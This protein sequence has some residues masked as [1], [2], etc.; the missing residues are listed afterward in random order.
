LGSSYHGCDRHLGASIINIS[1]IA[2]NCI[3]GI[4][5]GCIDLCGPNCYDTQNIKNTY[6]AH[7]HHGDQEWLDKSAI[8]GALQLYL[9]FINLF[10][11]LL[12]FMGN[13]E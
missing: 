4:H 10:M 2:S 13:R 1:L 11:F 5:L 3:C 7:A 12:Q 9:D 6:I 8:H